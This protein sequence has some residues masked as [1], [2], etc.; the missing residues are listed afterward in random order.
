MTAW[1]EGRTANLIVMFEAWFWRPAPLDLR[2]VRARKQA[3][4]ALGARAQGW[5]ECARG[6]QEPASAPNSETRL[7]VWRAARTGVDVAWAK[8]V[9]PHARTVPYRS[10]AAKGGEQ[11]ECP[12]ADA[13]PASREAEE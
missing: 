1:R 11:A 6:Q 5:L 2:P 4:P 7:G 9:S 3:Q 12:L 13:G 10:F 8:Q